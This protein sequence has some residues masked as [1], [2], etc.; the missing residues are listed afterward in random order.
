LAIS[1]PGG[2]PGELDA[3]RLGQLAP[4]NLVRT[5]SAAH[6]RGSSESTWRQIAVTEMITTPP[7]SPRG[8]NLVE[9]G[10]HLGNRAARCRSTT[11]C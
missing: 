8:E 5:R 9:R 2:E 11:A 10:V 6:G 4:E 7:R 1:S 3:P